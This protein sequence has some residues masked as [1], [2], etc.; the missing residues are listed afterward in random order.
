MFK[1]KKIIQYYSGDLKSGLG[2]IP[3][4]QKKVDLQIVRIS[5]G[6]WN[7]ESQPVEF[8][9]N[10]RHYIKNHLKSGQKCPDFDLSGFQMVGTIAIALPSKNQTI[11]NPIFKKFGFQMFPVFKWLDFCSPLYKTCQSL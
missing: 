8:Q 6:I 3:N 5:D 10:G 7:P 9:T 4:G 11:W 1:L 2:W